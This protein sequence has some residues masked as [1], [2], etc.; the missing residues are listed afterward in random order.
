MD[1]NNKKLFRD[2]EYIFHWQNSGGASDY[3][4]NPKRVFYFELHSLTKNLYL[5]KK[6][7]TR[8]LCNQGRNVVDSQGAIDFVQLVQLGEPSILYT[9]VKGGIGIF[10]AYSKNEKIIRYEK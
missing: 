8:H 1:R 7:L 9:N 2:K 6:S 5:Y 3:T 10:A 4:P